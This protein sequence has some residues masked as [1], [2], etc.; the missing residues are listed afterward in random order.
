MSMELAL[1]ILLITIGPLAILSGTGS[2][3][4]DT[5]DVQRWWPGRR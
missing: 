3:P 4:T 1:L 5:R 2:A